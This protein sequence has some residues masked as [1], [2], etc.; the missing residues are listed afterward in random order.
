MRSFVFS[1]PNLV[2]YIFFGTLLASWLMLGVEGYLGFGLYCDYLKLREENDILQQKKKALADL[3]LRMKR[4]Q[5][6]TGIIRNVLGLEKQLAAGGGLG[7]GGSPTTDLSFITSKDALANSS[8]ALPPPAKSVS[9]LDQAKFLQENLREVVETVRER[10]QFLDS[11][12]SIVPVEAEDY[13]LSCGFGW[14]RSPFTGLKEFHDGLDISAPRGTPIIAPGDSRVIRI[15]PHR[16]RGKYLQLDH[17]WDR[18]TTYAHLSR[19][20]VTMGQKIKRGDVIGFM[21]STGRSTGPHLHY[22]VEI[23]GKVV[24]PMHYILN[25]KPN[26]LLERPLLA[27]SVGQ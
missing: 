17:G 20:N 14:R 22:E 6:D 15:G 2:V 23:N 4:I 12:P 5:K 11:T 24:N 27:E 25:A 26:L 10:Q 7:Q 19:F 8:I 16:Y 9:I 3:R 1:I 21:G 18:F 13:W